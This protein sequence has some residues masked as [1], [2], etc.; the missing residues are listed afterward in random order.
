MQALRLVVVAVLVASLMPVPAFAQDRQTVAVTRI[1]DGDTI[2]VQTDSGQALT[3]RLL[4]MDTPETHHPTKPV[5]CYGPEATA[6]T[7]EMLPPGTAIGLER[8]VQEFDRYGRTLA[9]VWTV[10]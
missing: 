8:D 6:R 5:Q 9:Y 4:G 1:V 10:D 7:A 3:V 2:H